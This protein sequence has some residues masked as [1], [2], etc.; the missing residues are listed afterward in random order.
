MNPNYQLPDSQDS[1]GFGF[2]DE[3][4]KL[5]TGAMGLAQAAG[6]RFAV[7]PGY[8]ADLVAAAAEG[9]G[10]RRHVE[11][12]DR[13]ERREHLRAFHPVDESPWLAVLGSFGE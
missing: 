7:S 8:A 13:I 6:A 11:V 9:D 3:F 12:A 10:H 1:Y 4:A 5:T 2:L